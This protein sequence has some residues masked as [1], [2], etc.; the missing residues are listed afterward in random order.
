MLTDR[1]QVATVAGD[2]IVGG[3]RYRTLQYPIVCMVSLDDVGEPWR[4]NDGCGLAK[5]PQ[6]LLHVVI[7]PTEFPRE[8]PENFV[9]DERR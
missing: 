2:Q 7:R 3:D 4:V 1:Q 6:C 9:Q 8:H 5:P